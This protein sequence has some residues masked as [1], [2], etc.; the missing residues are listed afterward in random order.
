MSELRCDHKLHGILVDDHTLETR[1]G[2]KFCGKAPGVVV[3]HRFDLRTGGF[4]TRRYAEPPTNQ[5]ESE[6]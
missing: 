1:C 5:H 2:S 6:A 4:T 3:I